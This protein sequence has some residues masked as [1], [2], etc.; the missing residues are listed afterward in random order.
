M[1]KRMLAPVPSCATTIFI[2]EIENWRSRPTITH[3]HPITLLHYC[4]ASVETLY[5]LNYASHP[6]NRHQNYYNY[7]CYTEFKRT[8]FLF[9]SV[10]AYLISHIHKQWSTCNL[11]HQLLIFLKGTTAPSDFNV[12]PESV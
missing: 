6:L 10:I 12:H 11:N 7:N 2:N 5:E 4:Y 8:N 1:Y 9:Y 3:T